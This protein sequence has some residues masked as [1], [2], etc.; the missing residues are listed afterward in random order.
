VVRSQVPR[1][2]VPVSFSP[3]L[4]FLSL[5]LTL[6]CPFHSKYNFLLSA[7]LD[8]GIQFFVF[9]STLSIL[10]AAYVLTSSLFSPPTL[11]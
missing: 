7:A 8:A 2:L 3:H 11:Y 4:P 5:R 1:Y 9:I 6:L 10:G